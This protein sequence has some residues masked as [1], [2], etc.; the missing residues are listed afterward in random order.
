[1]GAD[2]ALAAPVALWPG[3]SRLFQP[4]RAA[5]R[6]HHRWADLYPIGS[7]AC[8]AGFNYTPV[9]HDQRN[10]LNVGFNGT[11]PWHIDAFKRLLRLRLQQWIPGT[12]IALRWRLSSRPYYLRPESWETVHRQLFISVTA[13]NVANWRILLD[14]SLTFGGF[15]YND[16]SQIYGEVR[17]RFKF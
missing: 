12:S 16:P 15:H 4:D 8:D 7:P 1:M 5:A 2:P 3:S 17:Y 14:N 6:Q 11:L 10:T 9:D 13:L